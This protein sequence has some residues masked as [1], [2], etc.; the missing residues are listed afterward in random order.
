V[1]WDCLVLE[2]IAFMGG[3]SSFRQLAQAQDR[4]QEL[5]LELYGELIDGKPSLALPRARS[6]VIVARQGC[7]HENQQLDV[8]DWLLCVTDIHHSMLAVYHIL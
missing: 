5:K 1:R 7:K 6:R 3:H 8:K 4:G 2:Q